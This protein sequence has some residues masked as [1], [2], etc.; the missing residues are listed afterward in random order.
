[1]SAR[2]NFKN[3]SEHPL[4]ALTESQQ[5]ALSALNASL[6]VGKDACLSGHAGT[7]KTLLTARLLS[8]WDPEVVVA[9]AP[10]HKAVRVLSDFLTLAGVPVKCMTIHAALGLRPKQ[11]I[12]KGQVILE[13][14]GNIKLPSKTSLVVVDEASMVGRALLSAIGHYSRKLGFTVLFVG[15]P[16]QLP[17]VMEEQSCAFRLSRKAVLTEV[18]RQEGSSPVIEIADGLRRTIEGTGPAPP[19]DATPCATIA[20]AS[21][22]HKW[23]ASY[24]HSLERGQDVKLLAWTNEAV[25]TYN[26]A[27]KLAVEGTLDYQEGESLVAMGALVDEQ[28]DVRVANNSD[29]VIEKIQR[30]AVDPFGVEACCCVVRATDPY[31]GMEAQLPVKLV[32][33]GSIPLYLQTVRRLVATASRLQAARRAHDDGRQ[34]WPAKL[35]ESRKAAWRAYFD[36]KANYLDARPPYALTVHKS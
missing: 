23:L 2:V 6:K 7:G 8:E 32:V 4:P 33:D 27:I 20:R 1:M 10:T 9:T 16:L 14:T 3:Y 28:G 31:T 15:D 24:I 11:D 22:R 30:T 21:N 5:Q 29:I 13:K 25:I 19:I 35:E 36:Y 18:I 34:S 26:R 17:P 12:R